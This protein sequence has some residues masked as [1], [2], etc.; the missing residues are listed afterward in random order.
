[1]PHLFWHYVRCLSQM[2]SFHLKAPS[3]ADSFSCY[4]YELVGKQISKKW[5]IILKD[6]ERRREQASPLCPVGSSASQA[7]A[8]PKPEWRLKRKPWHI[9][10]GGSGHSG[11]HV[12]N[13]GVIHVR[14][15]ARRAERKDIDI[16]LIITNVTGRKKWKNDKGERT[17]YHSW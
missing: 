9:P 16:I 3:K 10:L 4:M 1:M 17:D 15:R 6:S 8:C 11:G 5:K 7:R 14:Q 2:Q 12:A 13:H